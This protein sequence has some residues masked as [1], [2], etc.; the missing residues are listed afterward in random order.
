VI[1]NIWEKGDRFLKK[2]QAAIDKYDVGAELSGV[3]P[4]FFIT[5]K[6][7]ETGAY[8]DKRTDFYTQLIRKGFFFTP[9]HHAYISYSHAEADLDKTVQAVEES[10]AYLQDKYKR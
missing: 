1:D 4:M 7:D 10:M 6:K 2:I 3:A 9:H 8:K 5:F